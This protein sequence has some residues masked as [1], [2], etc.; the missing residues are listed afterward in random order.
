MPKLP[1]LVLA[2]L[3]L[4]L[5]PLGA[6][7]A[8]VEVA[9]SS[10][11]ERNM[12]ALNA[13]ERE[14]EENFRKFYDDYRASLTETARRFDH[15][16][17]GNVAWA[18]ETLIPN[19]EDFT[20]E[21]FIK[22]LVQENLRRAGFDN[23]DGTIRVQVDRIKVANHSLSFIANSQDFDPVVIRNGST[24]PGTNKDSYVLG[25]IQHVDAAG[26]VVKSVKISANF[27]YDVTVDNDYQGPGFAFSVTDP[28][29][30]V[31]PALTRFVEK[32]LDTLF[33]TEAFYG[34]V[35]VGP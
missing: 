17:F 4:A 29:F 33:G 9:F 3:L 1:S 31:G 23:V 11:L 21:N 15:V 19:I 2:G 12:D 24:S 25:S 18:G 27:I 26:N 10:K 13:I 6:S 32:G 34:A 8:N 20:V 5:C 30:R 22:A 35:L 16:K 28:S 7:A 14:R